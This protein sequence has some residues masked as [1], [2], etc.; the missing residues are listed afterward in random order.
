MT[1]LFTKRQKLPLLTSHIL[2]C[3]TGISTLAFIFNQDVKMGYLYSIILLIAGIA[4]GLLS[5]GIVC[6]IGTLKNNKNFNGIKNE[7]KQNIDRAFKQN[8]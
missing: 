8:I 3:V 6:I 5:Y 2:R 7:I 1:D 4:A